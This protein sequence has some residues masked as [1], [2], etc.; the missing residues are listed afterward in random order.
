MERMF[1][2]AK[3]HADENEV[4]SPTLKI[5]KYKL[6]EKVKHD[7]VMDKIN[8]MNWAFYIRKIDY[9]FTQPLE[10]L[11]QIRVQLRLNE[12]KENKSAKTELLLPFQD[13]KLKLDKMSATTDQ[14]PGKELILERM[15]MNQ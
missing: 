6:I 5:R 11:D 3:A 1:A 2:Q 13:F 7:E 15:S 4:E 14:F 10:D 9:S 12:M 8:A